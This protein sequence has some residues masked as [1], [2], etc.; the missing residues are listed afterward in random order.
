M[1][2]LLHETT[3][4][5]GTCKRALPARVLES[6]GAVVMEKSCPEHGAQR[7]TLASDARWYEET[8][9]L[10]S[11]PSPP[12]SLRP[13]QMGCPFDCGPCTQH[14]Q[15]VRLPVVT[16]TSACNL[17][18]PMCYVH[19]KNDDPYHMSKEE[20]GRVLDALVASRGGTL[21]LVNLTGGDPTMHPDLIG[22]LEL[23]R[24]RGITRV[25]VCTNGI[26]LVDDP[27]LLDALARLDARIALSFQS[28]EVEADFALQGAKLVELKLRILDALEQRGLDTTLIPVASKGLNDGELGRIVRLGIER[29]NVRHVEIHTMTFTGQGGRTFDRS[30]RTSVPEVLDALERTT[31]GLLRREHFVPSP[32]AHPLCYQIAY[33]LLDPEGGP[34]IPFTDILTRD[35]LRGCLSEHLYLEP[36]PRL[37]QALRAAIDRL[38]VREDDVERPL[39]I[40][41]SL[42]ASMFPRRPISRAEALRVGERA[43][44]AVYVHSHMDEDTFDVERLAECCDSNCYADG[45]TI[46]VCAYNVLYREKEPRFMSVPAAWSTRAGGARSLP[47]LRG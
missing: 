27:A 46:P 1:A 2:R 4:L 43:A 25:S 13:V 47:V 29:S 15:D 40:L 38:F 34:P 45:T 37:E 11:V 42:L 23:C 26:R 28:L 5:C 24:D 39:R 20:F 10:R 19:N 21:D 35:E 30:T 3:S 9:A 12:A 32:S 22:L 36:S 41:K 44:K 6:E 17:R 7:V 16:I 8:R 31:G 33:L 14:T 18:C